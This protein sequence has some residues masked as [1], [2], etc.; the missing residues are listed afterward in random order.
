MQSWVILAFIGAVLWG[1]HYPLLEKGLDIVS[2]LTVMFITSL[3]MLIVVL[4]IHRDLLVDLQKISNSGIKNQ[5]FFLGIIVTQ[6]IAIYCV[7]KAI[8]LGN[9]TYVSLIEISY[10]VF[11]IIFGY[12][13]FKVNHFN[14]PIIIGSIMIFVGSGLIVM[15]ENTNKESSIKNDNVDD[16]DNLIKNNENIIKKTLHT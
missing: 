6:F 8:S 1:I 2:P 13:L 11:V 15:N 4:V 7:T 10:P 5:L 9:A 12:L 3:F 14:L 16:V